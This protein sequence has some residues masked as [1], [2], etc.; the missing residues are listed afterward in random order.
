MKIEL[1]SLDTAYYIL[2]EF[3]DKNHFEHEEI[4]ESDGE[5]KGILS[6]GYDPALLVYPFDSAIALFRRWEN[7]YSIVI[8]LDT[9]DED[10]FS[11]T[12]KKFEKD[13]EETKYKFVPQNF[14]T[15]DYQGYVFNRGKER[16]FCIREINEG[17]GRVIAMGTYGTIPFEFP[18]TQDGFIRQVGALEN[19]TNILMESVTVPYLDREEVKFFADQVIPLQP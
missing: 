10:L 7:K 11:K 14:E 19:I 4:D 18:E 5:T 13:I 3:Y 1:D 2:G 16:V 15:N 6:H 17:Q 9:L 8:G 12:S